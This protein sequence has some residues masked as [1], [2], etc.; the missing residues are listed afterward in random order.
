[1]KRII[2]ATLLTLFLT[3]GVL[4]AQTPTSAPATATTV[5]SVMPALEMLQRR[6]DTLKDFTAKVRKEDKS[7]FGDLEIREGTAAYQ[8]NGAVTKLGVHFDTLRGEDFPSAKLD[9]DMVFDGRLFV[10][11]DPKAKTFS[12]QELVPEGKHFD[13]LKLGAG[14]LPLPIGQDPQEILK[15]FTVS[16]EPVDA[17]QTPKGYQPEDLVHLKLIPKSEGRYAF[18]VADLFIDPKLELPIKVSTLSAGGAQST[19]IFSDVQM[20]QGNPKILEI[21][22]PEQGTGWSVTFEPYHEGG[23][24]K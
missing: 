7:R 8:K 21:K 20:N 3:P 2:S 11:R 9:E 6:G 24:R 19:V 5:A 22:E 10:H 13:P 1:M 12:R 15:N 4:W 18:K 23:E 14:P 16:L 17:K